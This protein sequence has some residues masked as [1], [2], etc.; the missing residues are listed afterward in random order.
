MGQSTFPVRQRDVG[1]VVELQY[2]HSDAAGNNSCLTQET[3]VRGAAA[4]PA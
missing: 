4:S 3:W 2:D 1:A